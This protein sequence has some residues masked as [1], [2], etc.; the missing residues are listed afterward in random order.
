MTRYFLSFKL[1]LHTT[2][3]LSSSYHSFFHFIV[4]LNYNFV[5]VF[6]IEKIL[7]NIIPGRLRYRNGGYLVPVI[8]DPRRRSFQFSANHKTLGYVGISTNFRQIYQELG[9]I[10]V[11]RMSAVAE[12]KTKLVT[13]VNKSLSFLSLPASHLCH[14]GLG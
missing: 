7:K 9:L 8:G 5:R 12:Q 3:P 1:S 6:E 2:V 11:M 10:D 13:C 14:Q 4:N